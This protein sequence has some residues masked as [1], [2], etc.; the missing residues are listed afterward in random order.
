[1]AA[2]DVFQLSSASHGVA[3]LRMQG[4][5]RTWQNAISTKSP[6]LNNDGT[7]TSA[8]ADASKLV[9]PQLVAPP[10]VANYT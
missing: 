2:V 4:V 7:H 1:M 10:L 3:R 8:D 9:A 6:E 5:T